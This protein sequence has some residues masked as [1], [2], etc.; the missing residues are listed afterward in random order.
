MLFAN[1]SSF[2]QTTK[3]G[4]AQPT[5]QEVNQFLKKY[6]PSYWS[7]KEK[8]NSKAKINWTEMIFKDE[9]LQQIFIFN[10]N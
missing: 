3:V 2:L 9:L 1:T 6:L 5:L 4:P 8:L 7:R 10:Q